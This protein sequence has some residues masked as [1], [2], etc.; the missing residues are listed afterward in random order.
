MAYDVY[1]IGNAL[2]DMEYEVDDDFLLDNDVP[3]GLMSLVDTEKM[4]SIVTRLDRSPSLRMSGGSAANTAVAVRGFGGR[5]FYSCRVADDATGQFFLSEL[6]NLGIETNRTGTIDDQPSGR[7]VSMVTEDAERSMYTC[8]GVSES[9]DPTDVVPSAIAQSHYL[10]VEGYLC[11]SPTGRSAAIRA[12]E[13][14]ES[15][16][17]AVTMTLSD[18]SMIE[19]FRDE[20]IAMLGNGVTHLFCNSEEALAWAK[21][22]RLDIAAQELRDIAPRLTIT[23][24]AEGALAIEGPSNEHAR[25]VAT[26]AVDTTGAG[27]MFAGA[28]I[29]ALSQGA[30]LVDASRFANFCAAKTVSQFGARLATVADY[31]ALRRAFR[32]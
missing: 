30:S 28:C 26:R 6:A 19:F 4:A 32:A 1:G 8:L 16:G 14:A 21:T 24:G 11:S 10:Y 7:C 17:V 22:D 27:D 29:F 13:V 12:R 25:G 15:E 5:A 18:P 31:Q 9:L 2:V 3:K 20:L 23:M